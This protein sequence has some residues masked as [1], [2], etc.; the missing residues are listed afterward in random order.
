MQK[1]FL[2]NGVIYITAKFPKG[3]FA[4]ATL[5][6]NY[7]GL[8]SVIDIFSKPDEAHDIY[9]RCPDPDKVLSEMRSFIKFI[10]AGGGVVRNTKNE[11]LMIFRRGVWDLPK[12]KADPGESIEQTAL[13]EVEEECSITGLHV[14]SKRCVTYHFYMENHM[15]IIKE[16]HWFNMRTDF[17][18][19]L[20]PQ[21]EEDIEEV[22]WMDDDDLRKALE[23]SYL[24]IKEVLLPS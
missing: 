7:N 22:K 2:R 4:K 3:P 16:T 20:K 23:N 13:R 24:T 5:L 11:T 10:P 8:N 9:L 1:I 12:G 15:P 18:G 17:T 14:L 19:K 21:L 6:L